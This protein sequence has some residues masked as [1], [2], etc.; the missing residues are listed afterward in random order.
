MQSTVAQLR[1]AL[2]AGLVVCPGA[3]NALTAR[4]VEEAGF[5]ACYVTGAGIA[6]TWLAAPDIG[7]LTLSELVDHVAAMRD[8]VD[9]PLVVD[10]DTGFGN[11]VG[12]RRTVRALE[13]AGAAAIQ[14]E[15][16][17][18]PKR[19]GHFQGKAV[20]EVS[21]MVHKVASAVDARDEALIIARTD[22]RAVAGIDAALERAEAYAAA[23]ADLV[24]V[25]A[26]ETVD[27][28]LSI[29]RRLPGVPH[30]ANLVDGGRT[31]LLRADQLEGFALAVYANLTLQ[32]M[33]RGVGQALAAL[34]DSGDI[35]AARPFL[36]SWA[37]RQE[38]VRKDQ[39]DALQTRFGDG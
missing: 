8:A 31:P 24:F 10:G 34:R 36:A 27:E 4:L 37:E 6:N 18:F 3:A 11:A 2:D 32:A 5:E 13:R 30:V 7:L 39:Y 16:Q 33:I 35:E 19:C 38:L 21:E 26:P 14:L 12:V 29:P 23:G 15:D 20:V 9:I 28:L 1:S 17:V 22:A 25:E